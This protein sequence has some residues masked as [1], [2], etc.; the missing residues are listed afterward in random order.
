[1]KA[2]AYLR[3]STVGQV[4]GDGF[5]RQRAA[6]DEYAQKNDLQVA[7]YFHEQGV[8]GTLLE[9]P[10]WQDLVFE[11]LASGVTIILI[12]RLDRLARDLIVQETL[13]GDLRKEGIKLIS[14][15]EPDLCSD[16]P[17][18]KLIRQVFGAIAEYDRD[19]IVAKLKAARVRKKQATGRC[20]GR[21]PYGLKGA[22]QRRVHRRIFKL[23]NEGYSRRR[24]ALKL[25][26]ERFPAPGG[27]SKWYP[28]TVARIVERGEAL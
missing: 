28:G 5:P 21:L 13:L 10:A 26:Q 14:T 18:R 24:I 8:S 20:E 23:L 1:M 19:M 4:D 16:D 7:R 3:V 25:N 6:I 12:E 2:F 11:A 9:R 15:A 22:Q 17:S 27:G